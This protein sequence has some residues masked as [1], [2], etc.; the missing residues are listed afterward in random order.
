MSA[1]HRIAPP[2]HSD[3]R[4]GPA[5]RGAEWCSSNQRCERHT[6]P[7]SNRPL[8]ERGGGAASHAPYAPNAPPAGP[9]RTVTDG[10]VVSEYWDVCDSTMAQVRVAGP[11][12]APGRRFLVFLIARRT[13][14][15]NSSTNEMGVEFHGVGSACFAFIKCA[16]T[17]SHPDS[18][19]RTYQ[20]GVHHNHK[21]FGFLPT[22][23]HFNLPRLN[24]SRNRK[25]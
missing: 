9:L 3:R 25:G 19:R 23:F 20:F 17:V 22:Y 16:G 11:S 13:S 5:A 7:D 8:Q 24:S 1:H 10:P 14:W 12:L 6:A 18:Q 15:T 2:A 4:R 21:T